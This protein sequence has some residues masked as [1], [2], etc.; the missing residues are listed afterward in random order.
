M[1]NS[2]RLDI[3]RAEPVGGSPHGLRV[4][5]RA[6]RSAARSLRDVTMTRKAA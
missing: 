6:R 3:V 4:R 5:E 2:V 1:L